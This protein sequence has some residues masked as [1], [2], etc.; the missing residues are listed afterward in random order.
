MF[1]PDWLANSVLVKK[2]DKWRVC[3]DF[4]NLIEACPKDNF[5][6][7]KIDQLVEATVGHELLSFMDAYSGYN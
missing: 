3:I 5:P 1:F 2:K 6:L 4:T 7:P